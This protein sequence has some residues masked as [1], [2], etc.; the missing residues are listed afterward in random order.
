METQTPPYFKFQLV[1]TAEYDYFNLF[2]PKIKPY[3][4][5]YGNLSSHSLLGHKKQEVRPV[6]SIN[7]FHPLY[8][9]KQR[10]LVSLT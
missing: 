4:N 5:L 10:V 6:H 3:S 1:H 2:F 7:H 8:S 9:V